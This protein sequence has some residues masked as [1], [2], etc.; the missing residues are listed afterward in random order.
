MSEECNFAG[1][2]KS[3][4]IFDFAAMTFFIRFIS[5]RL[6]KRRSLHDDS[7]A[8]LFPYNFKSLYQSVSVPIYQSERM[9]PRWRL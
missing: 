5:I 4:G 7:H 2:G 1:G 8:L 9:R 3:T 6:F